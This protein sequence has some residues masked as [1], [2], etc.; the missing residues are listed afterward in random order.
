MSN[1]YFQYIQRTLTLAKQGWPSVSPNPLVAC[2]IVSEDKIVAEGFHKKYG[3]AHAEVNA[4]NNLPLNIN[5]KDCTLYVNLEPCS[6]QGKTPPC[7]DLI[8]SKGFKKVVICNLDPNPLVAGKGIQKLKTAGIEV[9]TGV[10]EKEGAELNKRFFT[11]HT[12]HRPFF[13]LKWAQTADGFIS[14]WPLSENSAENKPH[15]RIG[16]E[17][18]QK[19]THQMRAEESAIMVGKNTVLI[20]NPFLTT[21]IV[22]GKNPVR[23]F[24][25]KNLEVPETFNIYNKESETIVIN[26]I[27]QEVK[28]NIR[29]IKIN[30]QENVLK[31]IAQ[32][33]FELK[34]QSVLVEGGAVLLNSFIKEKLA[35]E[36]FIFENQ[37]LKFDNGIKAPDIALPKSKLKMNDFYLSELQFR[38]YR[39][40]R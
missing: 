2:V 4:I 38:Y 34:I 31:Q 19:M 23:I 12:K 22:K 14:R 37:T 7:A 29:F 13:I 27:K 10:L 24:I 35:D 9:I 11:F 25:D 15:Q 17:E 33:L 20:D 30:F 36:I 1:H 8:I 28:D 5:P 6:H 39:E 32:K 18:Q 26:G 21:R 16:N 40:F 3:E